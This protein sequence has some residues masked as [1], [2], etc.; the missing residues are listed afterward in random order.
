[1]SQKS[2]NVPLSRKSVNASGNNGK[3]V[4]YT[5]NQFQDRDMTFK[6]IYTIWSKIS[7]Y[8]GDESSASSEAESVGEDM[9]G[10]F[11]KI[12]EQED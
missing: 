4:I 6:Y 8:A 3:D 9:P 10:D 1:M 2:G 11:T 12:I 7:P 5:F